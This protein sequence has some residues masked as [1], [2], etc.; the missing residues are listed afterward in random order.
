MPLPVA[1]GPVLSAQFTQLNRHRE[2]AHSDD[3]D[4]IQSVIDSIRG[5]FEEQEEHQYGVLRVGWL[6]GEWRLILVIALWRLRRDE[7]ALA[8]TSSSRSRPQRVRPLSHCKF[9]PVAALT[10]AARHRGGESGA[11]RGTRSGGCS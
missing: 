3:D 8:T 5:K 11:D 9:V 4:V 1:Q 10:T 2:Q 7:E 6:A